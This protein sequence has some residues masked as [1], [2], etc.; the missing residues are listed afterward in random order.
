MNNHITVTCKSVW[1][2]SA[3]D[4]ERFFEWIKKIPS[5]KKY[6]GKHDELYLHF[7]SNNIADDDLRELLALFYRYKIKNMHQ[8]KLFLNDHNRAWFHGNEKAFWHKKVFGSVGA[9]QE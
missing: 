6:D 1:Y 3:L 2:Y 4:E 8:L 7:E 9:K 5:I